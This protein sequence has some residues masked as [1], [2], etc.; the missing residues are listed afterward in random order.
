MDSRTI[1]L[2]QSSWSVAAAVPDLTDRFYA[3][4]FATNPEL[5]TLFSA[6]LSEQGRKL[7]RMLDAVVTRLDD[8]D[9]FIPL[10]RD[11]GERHDLYG[12]AD[13]DYELVGDALLKT[14]AEVLD[15]AFTPETE[16]A[17][18]TVYALIA[19]TMRSAAHAARG[20]FTGQD[21]AAPLT[22]VAAL[23]R[24]TP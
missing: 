19:Q 9:A 23:A 4:L 16:I 6:D 8:L 2:V 18:A 21:L 22:G 14:L 10:L 11:L 12:V 20:R 3:R 24:G 13:A 17:W 5:R 7:A 1:R 15:A